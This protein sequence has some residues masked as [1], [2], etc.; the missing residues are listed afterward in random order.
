M[1]GDSWHEV[2][3][4]GDHNPYPKCLGPEV[5]GVSASLLVQNICII[6]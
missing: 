2:D 5:F 1:R 4:Q 3:P 6:Y